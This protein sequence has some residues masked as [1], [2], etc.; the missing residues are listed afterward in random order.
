VG[1]YWS[2]MRPDPFEKYE[3]PPAV[4][5]VDKPRVVISRGVGAP[6][7]EGERTQYAIDYDDSVDNYWRKKDDPEGAGF[8]PIREI[9]TFEYNKDEEKIASLLEEIAAIRMR[10]RRGAATMKRTVTYGPWE[11]ISEVKEPYEGRY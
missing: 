11:P 8:R 9:M 3:P 10:T 7:D 6:L 4:A 2:E 1:H 5:L